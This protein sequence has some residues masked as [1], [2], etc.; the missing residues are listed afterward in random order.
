MPKFV[1]WIAE[2]PGTETVVTAAD[3]EAAR[4]DFGTA[5]GQPVEK[6]EARI[7]IIGDERMEQG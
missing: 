7:F 6:V 4:A 3:M 2:Q 1:V 5:Q